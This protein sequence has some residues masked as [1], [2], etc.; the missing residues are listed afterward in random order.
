MDLIVIGSHN[1]LMIKMRWRKHC[2]P[3]ILPMDFSKS[4]KTH[5]HW[6]AFFLGFCFRVSRWFLLV[7][8]RFKKHYTWKI[9]VCNYM[10]NYWIRQ[11]TPNFG[12]QLGKPLLAISVNAFTHC[13]R[14]MPSLGRKN[15]WK[16]NN[17]LKRNLKT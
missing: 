6:I 14:Q 1:G 17:Y 13:S 10:T 3:D 9:E 12:T 11:W 15:E 8:D 16:S 7:T 2:I 5:K 4:S